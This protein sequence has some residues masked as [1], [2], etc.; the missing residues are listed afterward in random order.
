MTQPRHI[1]LAALLAAF[2]LT[3][4]AQT[5]GSNSPYSR[6][7][8]G[9]LGDGGNAFNKGMAGTAYAMR[10]GKQVN[11]KNPA[12]YSA[13]DSLTFLF[14]V[15]LS[16]QHGNLSQS[17]RKAN[18]E[19]TSIDY[20]NMGFRV[21][22]RLGMSL[23]LMPFS[24]V[25]YKT[26][27]E[28]PLSGTVGEV[29]QTGTYS[30]DGGMHEVYGGLGW[31]PLKSLSLGANI[32]YLWGN[33]EHSS[34]MTFDDSNI[35]TTQQQYQA[36]IRTYKASFGLQYVQPL[37]KKQ[38]LTLGFTY[39]LGHRVNRTAYFYNQMLTS[40]SVVGGDTASVRNAFELPHTFGAGMA[41]E[42]G[43]KWRVG[44]DYTFQKWGDVKF[45]QVVQ[46]PDGSVS[47]EARKGQ[48]SH[49]HRISVGAEYTPNVDGVKWR[50]FLRYQVGFAY[51]TP[52][53]RI[54]GNDGPRDYQASVG[55]SLP[56]INM[57][58]NRS[59]LNVAFQYE[60]VKPR[61]AGQVTENYFRLS[62]GLSFNE[63]WFMKWRAE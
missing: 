24:T 32:G 44:A 18:A 57:H 14:D 41:W 8:F 48:F 38:T 25:G 7:G 1:A 11:S 16:L 5:N 31:A 42:Y 56:I 20:L 22:P 27:Y 39:G 30:G 19:N 29:K 40:G 43:K 2:A 13:I 3:A 60:H 17:G 9:L 59:L 10:H 26:M 54:D 6:Y 34:T 12:S 4:A 51:T 23:G 62:L 61:M 53:T 45:P 37:G 15:G 49:L 63:R 46:Q 35:S 58:N 36:E 21:A 52:Y 33:L 55:V 50:Q 28:K 47:Y